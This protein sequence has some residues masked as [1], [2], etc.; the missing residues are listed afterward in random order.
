MAVAQSL[1]AFD[2][3]PGDMIQD[4]EAA[5][6]ICAAR[7]IPYLLDAC[8]ALGQLP[9]DGSRIQCD[10]LAATSR[11]FLR[12]PR[13]I[14]FL[15]VSDRMLDAGKDPLFIDLRGGAWTDPD[16]CQMAPGAERFENWECAYA[17]LLGLGEAARYP[18]AAQAHCAFPRTAAVIDMDRKL[19]PDGI[20]VSPHYYNTEADI[21]AL[22][23][24][25]GELLR[26]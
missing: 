23:D 26:T 8:Q 14:G 22:G 9:I 12:G 19:V 3:V 11:K 24:G 25:L 13:G 7:D 15:Y 5:G 17:S 1:S 18:T 2:F 10:F 21:A 4:A 6:R 20:R 16:Q